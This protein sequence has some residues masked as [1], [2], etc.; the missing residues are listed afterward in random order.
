MKGWL[1]AGRDV[2]RHRSDELA[3]RGAARV[4]GEQCPALQPRGEL[5]LQ[6]K[7]DPERRVAEDVMYDSKLVEDAAFLA[8][9]QR[10][11]FVTRDHPERR[12]RHRPMLAEFGT[13]LRGVAIGVS[14]V[15]D[16]LHSNTKASERRSTADD[17]EQPRG[18]ALERSVG[19]PD[20]VGRRRRLSGEPVGDP[21]SKLGWQEA[22]RSQ[23]ARR[24]R[25]LTR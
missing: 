18:L 16:M 1:L 3:E 13:E 23:H 8:T 4:T 17:V 11:R 5:G 6:V 14:V 10:M 22:R 20:G 21:L 19:V 9:K 12:E 7:P 2:R 24:E 25:G 15:A